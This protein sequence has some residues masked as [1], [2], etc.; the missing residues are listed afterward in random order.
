MGDTDVMTRSGSEAHPLG[1][2]ERLTIIKFN[3]NNSPT[4]VSP[5]MLAQTNWNFV[6]KLLKVN[7]YH[8]FAQFFS[9][10]ISSQL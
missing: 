8:P 2:G 6:E 5:A 3:E 7:M 9:L 4:C 10:L 1:F